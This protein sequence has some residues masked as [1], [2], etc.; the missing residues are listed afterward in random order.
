MDLFTLI[1]AGIIAAIAGVVRG[2][3]GFGGA[4]VMAPPLALLL[5]PKLAV[6][7]I[8][9]LESVAAA[10]ML[11]QTRHLVHWKMIGAIL[12]AACVTVPLGVLALVAIDPA[13]TRRIIAVTVIVFAVILLR[14]WRYA[15]RPR[16]AT[17]VGLGAVSGAMLGATSIGGPP[18]ILYLLSGP[19]PI[20]TTRANLTLY[21]A[22]S[23]LI[24]VIMLWHQGVFDA[25]AGWM[26]VLLAPAYYV[27]LLIG[28][29]LFPRFS[30]TLPSVHVDAADRRF[31]RDPACL[32]ALRR[33]RSKVAPIK[34][35][36][37]RASA[38]REKF[39]EADRYSISELANDVKRVCAESDNE[40]Q[41]LSRVRPLARRAALSKSTWLE[42]R[43]YEADATQGFGVHLIHEEP[44]HTIAILALAGCRTE[45]RR[46]TITAHGRSLP[47]STGR[48]RT[49]F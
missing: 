6:P 47:V 42:D 22:V 4:M 28:L 9:V 17:S 24:G 14:G 13:I 29:R 21:V 20:E 5:G 32:I 15:G 27:G 2:I 7:V 44:D 16:L 3:T 46:H 19:D 35:N 11:I 23:S 31:D 37:R 48:R 18:V 33:W 49:S 30:D 1:A 39:M 41:I 43:M 34:A 36:T 38:T 8:L 45:V 25:R 10:P 12:L 26:S 40:H